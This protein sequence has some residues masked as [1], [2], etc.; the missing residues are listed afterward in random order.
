MT[1]QCTVNM[2]KLSI[3]GAEEEPSTYLVTI[4]NARKCA[5]S[6]SLSLVILSLI[7]ILMTKVQ[8]QH[9]ILDHNAA[10]QQKRYSFPPSSSLKRIYPRYRYWVP[11]ADHNQ[12]NAPREN[13]A[14]LSA[15][16]NFSNAHPVGAAG[17]FLSHQVEFERAERVGIV[18]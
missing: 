15:I 9:S 6:F 17:K 10:W 5:D 16:V 8:S 11:A 14:L 18:V 12:P 7:S 4:K 1:W 2:I 3:T 13:R